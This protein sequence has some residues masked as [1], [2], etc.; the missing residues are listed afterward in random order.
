MSKP[1]LN[2]NR[3]TW[4]VCGLL[5]LASTIN[6]MDRQTLANTAKRV[7]DELKIDKV[8]YGR[9]EEGFG[10]AFAAGSIVFGFLADKI[11]VRWLYPVVLTGWSLAG[12]ATGYVHDFD[13]LLWCRVLL[14][15]FESGHWPCALLTTQRL[16][17]P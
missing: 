2:A 9:L 11:D 16:L 8:D 1:D 7:I 13:Q 4:I 10:F 17:A 15:F 3:W 12:I 6:Y 14:G 5:L